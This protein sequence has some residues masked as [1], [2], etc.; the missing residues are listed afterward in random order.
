MTLQEWQITLGNWARQ[1]FGPPDENTAHRCYLHFREEVGELS[2]A[3][4][5]EPPGGNVAEELADVAML[6]MQLATC[7][8]IDL[9]AEINKKHK[10]NLA[11]EWT[12]GPGGYHKHVNK[13]VAE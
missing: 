10:K 3:Y 7:L 13:E 12:K 9:E 8:G 5:G 4:F 1:V 2:D 11:R 6:S